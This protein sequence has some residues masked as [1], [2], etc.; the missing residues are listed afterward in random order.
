MTDIM[1]II[2]AIAINIMTPPPMPT[3]AVTAEVK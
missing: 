2:E 1:G 3:V